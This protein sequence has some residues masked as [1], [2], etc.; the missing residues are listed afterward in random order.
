MTSIL[1]FLETIKIFI[2]ASFTKRSRLI[3][4]PLLNP[5]SFRFSKELQ[6]SNNAIFIYLKHA[7]FFLLK[8]SS[9]GAIHFSAQINSKAAIFDGAS[10]SLYNRTEFLKKIA[11]PQPA[12]GFSREKLTIQKK[13]NKLFGLFGLSIIF[14]IL[15]IFNLFAKKRKA[16]LSILLLEYLEW[17]AISELIDKHSINYLYYFCAYENDS[18]MIAHILKK[19]EVY[20]NKIPSSNPLKNF[21]KY[22]VCDE[23]STTASFQKQEVKALSVNWDV[24]TISHYPID[25]YHFLTNYLNKN[26]EETKQFKLGFISSGIWLRQQKGDTPLGIGD[27]ESELDLMDIL[28][29]YIQSRNIKDLIILLHPIEKKEDSIYKQA[30]KHYREFFE[31]PTIQYPD[32]NQS[33]FEYFDRIDTTIAAYSSTNLQR[34]FCGYKTLYAP[35]KFTNNIYTGFD[36]ETIVGYNEKQIIQLLDNTLKM[37]DEL[38]FSNYKIERYHYKSYNIFANDY[39]TQ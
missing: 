30:K 9:D 5:H 34:L 21:Y 32:K 17:I 14:P 6:N 36:M 20:I 19:Q 7:L 8:K 28:K 23:L 25:S 39:S 18:N 1:I 10:K 13:T 26:L 15:L 31:L 22:L 3:V 12:V 29:R 2:S 33:S 16:T 11:N 37:N 38:F 4:I 35:T 27:Q 24:N